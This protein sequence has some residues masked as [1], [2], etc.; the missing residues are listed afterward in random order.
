MKAVV[1]CGLATLT[2]A[3]DPR[4]LQRAK[5]KKPRAEWRGPTFDS[6]S[7]VL[8][9]HMGKM[10]PKTKPCEEWTAK[11]LQ[12]FQAEAYAYR[13]THFDS[14]YA[15]VTDNRRMRHSSLEEHQ[16]Q[17]KQTNEQVKGLPHLKEMQRDGHCHE[18]VMW[19]VH[20]VPA[21]DQHSVFAR[22]PVPLLST[23]LHKCPDSAKS[24]EAEVCKVYDTQ[25]SCAE[26]HSG[27]GIVMQ[28]YSDP[29]GVIPEDPKFPGWARQR[30]CDQNYLPLCGP[31]EGIG[32]PYWGDE[33]DKFQPTNC[34]VVALPDAVP[35][36]DRQKPE[37][38]EQFIVHQLGSD[39][40]VRTQ[41]AA[42]FAIYSQIRSTLWY[43]FPLG[44]QSQGLAEDGMAKLRHDTY[45]DDLG[46]KWLDNGLVT[47][48]HLQSRA[49]RETNVTGPMVSMIHG[50]L[51][52]G[53]YLGGLTCLADPVGVPVLGGKVDVKGIDRP[54]G[55]SAFLEGA[56]YKGRIKIGVEYDGFKLGDKGHGDMTKKRNMTVDHYVKWFLHV[57]VDADKTSPTFGQPVRFYGPYSGFAVYVNVNKTQ[58]PADVWTDVCPDNGWDTSDFKPLHPCKGKKVTDY[59]AM[60]VEKKH[61]EVCDPWKPKSGQEL[62]KAS[63]C[64]SE[65][66]DIC[67]KNGGGDACITACGCAAGSCPPDRLVGAFGSM[68]VPEEKETTVVV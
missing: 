31:C 10:F 30:R 42:K 32:G 62:T 57:Y 19:L 20:H 24:D 29:D 23:K 44:G 68:F 18:A 14:I 15:N 13:H 40:L 16:E 6:M 49:Q 5:T 9:G 54:Q 37:F 56:D 21:A 22:M 11:E 61:P 1:L 67:C 33:I 28:D 58:P 3:L 35:E 47:E 38:A 50:L 8:N 39:R 63:A 64:D 25:K 48:I 17:W 27:S 7:S 4:D 12:D 2:P 60:V 43:D 41:N 46:Y 55:M 59:K 26:C 53:E 36:A 65:C 52:Y 34:E 51:G 45:Y 66:R